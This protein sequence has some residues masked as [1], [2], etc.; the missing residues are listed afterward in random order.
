MKI[1]ITSNS[2]W[3]L[4]NF[5]EELI[6]MIIE[7]KHE[8]YILSPSD[9]ATKLLLKKNITYKKIFLNRNLLSPFSDIILFFQ[10]MYYFIKLK[11]ILIL[12][13]T[14]KA[15]I[16]S[17]I[18]SKFTNIF[19]ISNITG[20]GTHVLKNN[21]IR[22]ILNFF[23]KFSLSDNYKIYFHNEDDKKYFIDNKILIENNYEVIPGSGINLNFNQYE[24]YKKFFDDNISFLYI[25]R[26]IK[27]KGVVELLESAKIIKREFPKTKFIFVG[28]IDKS[29]HSSI[30]NKYFSKFINDNI[31]EYMGKV[32]DVRNFIKNCSCVILP[33]YREGLSKSLLESLAL[34][35]P[36]ITTNVSGCKEI[37]KD[38]FNGFLCFPKN[39]NDL[40]NKIRKFINLDYK[41]K[42][43]FSLNT[44]KL[45]KNFDV[46][47]ILKSYQEEINKINDKERL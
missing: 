5:R 29:N 30:D 36:I 40:S 41:D 13:F 9:E 8:L 28:E 1:I 3:N 31:I 12:S 44:K 17:S 18:A 47:I 27:D 24:E 42:L 38:N 22:I 11:P 33:S 45:V 26:M 25:G 16:Y 46:Q 15:N 37:V 7:S 14:V 35:R 39:I 19:H 32:D 23:Y 6:D 43:N 34:G 10:Y 20:L 4:I 21:F 2:S